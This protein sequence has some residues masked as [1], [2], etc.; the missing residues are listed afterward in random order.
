MNTGFSMKVW[1]GILGIGLIIVGIAGI[2]S[3]H[4]LQG[5]AWLNLVIGIAAVIFSGS[6]KQTSSKIH[7]ASGPTVFAIILFGLWVI[8]MVIMP[9]QTWQAWWNF[10][11]A[12]AF[13]AMSIKSWRQKDVIL[14]PTDQAF[15]DERP[16]RSG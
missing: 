13:I 2:R 9:S 6:I 3:P 16:R 1:S 10:I 11:F 5:V 7:R 12:M 4:T 15:D 14:Q 8:E